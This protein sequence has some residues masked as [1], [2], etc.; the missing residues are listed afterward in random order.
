MLVTYE[1][2]QGKN[3]LFAVSFPKK[4]KGGTSDHRRRTGIKGGRSRNPASDYKYRKK[5]KKKKEEV[6]HPKAKGATLGKGQRLTAW[7]F[8]S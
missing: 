6:S 4:K 7:Y 8:A 2:L 5:E 3:I 1:K